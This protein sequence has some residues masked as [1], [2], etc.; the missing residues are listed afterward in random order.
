MLVT[1]NLHEA[2][3]LTGKPVRDEDDMRE[4]SRTLVELGAH[5]ALVKGGHLDGGAVDILW[6]GRKERIWRRERIPTR[7][8]HGT[9]CT[10]S[11]AV[12]AGVARGADLEGS[13]DRALRFVATA[14]ATAPG[15]GAGHGPVN[16][17]A[18]PD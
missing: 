10:L 1:P 6:D 17:F 8:T 15:L 13:V 9:G 11:A 7:H 12:A 16:H 5:A 18:S 2:G 4:A 14:I 3:I